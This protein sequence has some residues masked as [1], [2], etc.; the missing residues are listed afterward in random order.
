MLSAALGCR[1]Y[2]NWA[3][4][5]LC[6]MQ[7]LIPVKPVASGFTLNTNVFDLQHKHHSLIVNTYPI[8]SCTK[9]MPS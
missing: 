4:T 6:L 7:A 8:D 2:W 1:L 9:V 5:W 3:Y